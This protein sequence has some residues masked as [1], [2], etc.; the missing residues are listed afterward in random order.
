MTGIMNREFVELDQNGLNYLTWASDVEIVLEGKEIKG[1]LSAGTPMASRLMR[2]RMKLSKRTS[3]RSL[4]L[5]VQ[6][7]K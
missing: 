7:R 5:E 3:P 6:V 4:S 2:R 1:A